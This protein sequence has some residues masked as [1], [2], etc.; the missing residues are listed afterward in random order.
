MLA[1]TFASVI[2]TFK[3]D[4]SGEAFLL[5]SESEIALVTRGRVES[6][7]PKALVA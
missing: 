7:M 2:I 3:T 5:Q 6:Y 4:W 1:P